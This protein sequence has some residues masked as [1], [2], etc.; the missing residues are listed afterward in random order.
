M[1]DV[2]YLARKLYLVS[3]SILRPR[4]RRDLL[5]INYGQPTIDLGNT[6]QKDLTSAVDLL[7]STHFE[8]IKSDIKKNARTSSSDTTK[9]D[10]QFLIQNGDIK[11]YPN[12][13]TDAVFQYITA[14][15]SLTNSTLTSFYNA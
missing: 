12:I 14:A 13:F 1:V 5:T 2:N 9:Y 11:T 4:A 3:N 6:I 15:S 8:V 7:Q 10:I